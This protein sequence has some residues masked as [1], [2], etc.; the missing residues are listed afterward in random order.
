MSCNH[1]LHSNVYLE[2]DFNLVSV[3][4][5]DNFIFVLINILFIYFSL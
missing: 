4:Q 5:F 1:K 2:Y 3:Q